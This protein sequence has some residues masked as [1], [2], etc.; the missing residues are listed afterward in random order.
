MQPV[1][2]D[3]FSAISAAGTTVVSNIPATATRVIIPGTYVGTVKIHDASAAAGTS[4]TSQIVSFGLPATGIPQS[5]EVGVTCNKGIVTEA[6]G[7][8]TMTLVFGA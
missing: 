1:S 7:T 6:T 4:S 2:Q 8:P 3:Q 5:I